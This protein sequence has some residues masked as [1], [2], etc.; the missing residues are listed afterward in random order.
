MKNFHNMGKGKNAFL[1][2]AQNGIGAFTK[3]PPHKKAT[4][5]E[6]TKQQGKELPEQMTGTQGREEG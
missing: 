4:S 3:R 6:Q 1:H 5:S 2:G